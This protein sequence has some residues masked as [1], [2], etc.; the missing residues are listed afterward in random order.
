MDV[1]DFKLTIPSDLQI[2]LKSQ[3]KVIA[4]SIKNT[5]IQRF[6][7]NGM[8][9]NTLS[10]KLAEFCDIEN[11]SILLLPHVKKDAEVLK[12]LNDLLKG[13]VSLYFQEQLLTA[14]QLKFVVQQCD[15][16]ITGR[17]HLAIASLGQGTPISCVPYAN[18]FEG[19]CEHFKLN[20]SMLNLE[21][22]CKEPVTQLSARIKELESDRQII[23]HELPKIKKLALQAFKH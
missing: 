21:T 18:K 6:S 16:V 10:I 14:P 1:N 2:W 9:L 13:I 3:P 4:I 12:E 5:D 7:D 17:M 23:K 19:L 8:T 22:F 15:L 11:C 20:N